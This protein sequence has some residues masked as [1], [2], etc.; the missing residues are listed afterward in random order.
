MST[1]LPFDTSIDR[2]LGLEMAATLKKY[3]EA[4]QQ[5][6]KKLY[7]RTCGY[8][9]IKNVITLVRATNRCIRGF[10]VLAHKISVKSLQ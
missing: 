8:V 5:K 9:K 1:F 2:I 6:W 10:R 3:P 4:L 7:S